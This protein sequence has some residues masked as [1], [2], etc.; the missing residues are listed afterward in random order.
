V[1]PTESQTSTA[2][3]PQSRAEQLLELSFALSAAATLPEVSDAVMA[4]AK[5][6]FPDSAGA[7]IVR[8]SSS[9]DQL[10]IFA[11]SDLPGQVFENW[12]QFSVNEDAP[13]AECVRTGEILMLRSPAEWGARYPHLLSLLVE[14]G[15]RAQIMAPLVAGGATI[16]V[17]GVAFSIERDFSEDEQQVI[18]AVASQ[19]AVALERAR[20]FEKERELRE[21]AEQANRAKSDFLATVSHE[22]RTP[23]NAIGGYAQLIELGIHGPVTPDQLLAL[24]KI[25][26]SQLHIQGLINSVLEFTRIEAGVVQYHM[27]PVEVAECIRLC[28]ILT[29]TQKEEKH[30]TYDRGKVDASLRVHADPEKLRQVIIN[31]LTNAIKYTDPHGQITLCV[32]AI[33]Q[34]VLIRVTD[35]GEGIDDAETDAIF[36]PFVRLRSSG[37]VSEGIGLGLPISRRLARGMGGELTVE[38]TKGKGSTFTLSLPRA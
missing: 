21:A 5:R 37:V 22:L 30:L 9:E 20:L 14:T 24:G 16:G 31:M 7:I 36:E 1:G 12:R 17:L 25:Q 8:R 11:V 3:S 38:S 18:T 15:H 27:Q 13:M 28:E 6:I 33:D 19:C 34:R 2:Y 26:T 10:E 29:A 32:E 23:L 4:G 35:N